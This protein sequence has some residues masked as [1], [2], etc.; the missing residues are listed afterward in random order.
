[1]TASNEITTE[2]IHELVSYD[3]ESGVFTSK[4]QRGRIKVGDIVG[5]KVHNGSINIRLNGHRI[6]A[7]KL[8]YMYLGKKV[9]ATII[10]KDGD[11]SNNRW[12]NLT[13]N[14]VYQLEREILEPTQE[15]LQEWLDYNENTG[16]FTVKK[17][18]KGS[19]KQVGDIVGYVDNQSGY[20]RVKFDNKPY[21]AHRLSWVY[22]YGEEPKGVIDHINHN[23]LDNS[24]ANLRDVTDAENLKNRPMQSNNK[25]GYTGV[26]EVDGR[27]K[28]CIGVEGKTVHLGTFNTIDEAIEAR[29][30]AEESL[31]F[32]KNHGLEEVING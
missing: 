9:P 21:Q 6:P 15:N 5:S 7:H 20:V 27:W 18:V 12:D 10:H 19:H 25:S 1:M 28:A 2:Q 17:T 32:H 16:I 30:E 11:L 8:V 3:K 22:M 24:I 31:G 14:R 29:Q 4:T 26:Y 13:S 23:K